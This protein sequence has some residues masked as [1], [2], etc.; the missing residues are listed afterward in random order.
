M[1]SAD[2]TV[3]ELRR[4]LRLASPPRAWPGAKAY[5][6]SPIP[7][8]GVRA[9]PLRKLARTYWRSHRDQTMASLLPVV[10][11]LWEGRT[12]EERILALELLQRYRRRQDE[13]TWRTID[14]WVDSATGWGLS[15]SLAGGPIAEMVRADPSRARRLLRWARSGNP[16]RRRAS[17]YGLGRL[18]RAGEWSAVRPHFELLLEDEEFWVQR[19]VGTW[20]REAWKVQRAEVE[21]FLVARAARLPPVVRTVATERAP[22]AFRRRL[23]TLYEPARTTR[24]RGGPLRSGS[25]PRRRVPRTTSAGRRG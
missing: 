12:F 19:A 3:R 22:K 8:L 9:G 10:R 14:G 20:L 18:V 7:V 23:K 17:L 16:W 6:G 1:K 24:F 4:D 21:R 11:R 25:S 13:S 15:D 5:L 2:R